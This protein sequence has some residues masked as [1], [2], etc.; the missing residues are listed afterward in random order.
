[1]V[2]EWVTEEGNKMK[3]T[4]S[5]FEN[6]HIENGISLSVSNMSEKALGLCVSNYRPK[7]MVI[8]SLTTEKYDKIEKKVKK[9]K[10]PFQKL[11]I[12]AKNEKWLWLSKN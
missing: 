5:F 6:P 1:M 8:P 12:K 7:L 2:I 10:N 9:S 3:A 11:A 4:V